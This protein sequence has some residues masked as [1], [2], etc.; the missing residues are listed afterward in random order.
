[1]ESLMQPER[2]RARILMW[3]EEE[4]RAVHCRRSQAISSKRSF[5]GGAA[6]QRRGRRRGDG[7]APGAACCVGPSR[8]GG[9][10]LEEP[11]RS[12]PPRLSRYACL[13]LDAGTDFPKRRVRLI[14]ETRDCG[15]ESISRSYLIGVVPIASPPITTF[16]HPRQ[17]VSQ[18]LSCRQEIT[19]GNCKIFSYR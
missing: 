1:M 5:T 7:R 6:S 3:V 19:C 2:L 4:I 11:S 16:C 15:Q 10:R 18:P 12:P 8:E 17:Q 13:A 9:A 14:S